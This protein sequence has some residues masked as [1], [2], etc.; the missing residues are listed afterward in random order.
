MG[1]KAFAVRHGFT[2]EDLLQHLQAFLERK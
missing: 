1:R 2:E